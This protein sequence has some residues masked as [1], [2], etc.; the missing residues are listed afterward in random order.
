MTYIA[1][2]PKG[3]PTG[4]ITHAPYILS[5]RPDFWSETL[6]GKIDE[7]TSDPKTLNLLTDLIHFTEPETI[8]EV[9]TYR[10][11]GTAVFAETLRVY[12]LPGHVWSCDPVDHNVQRRP[13]RPVI[14]TDRLRLHRR[15]PQNRTLPTPPLYPAR[16]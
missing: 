5:A 4:R 8:V 1:S 10:G 7:M 15:V 11:W 14:H 13:P 2:D 3:T 16:A 12:N 6:G 9:G